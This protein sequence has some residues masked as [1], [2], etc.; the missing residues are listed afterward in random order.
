MKQKRTREAHR[1][2]PNAGQLQW[3]AGTCYNE[4]IIIVQAAQAAECAVVGCVASFITIEGAG[5]LFVVNFGIAEATIVNPTTI[6]NPGPKPF[7]TVINSGPAPLFF[8][9]QTCGVVASTGGR[10]SLSMIAVKFV[11]F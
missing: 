9:I 4:E 1:E 2:T 3:T 11:V 10:C 7:L 8:V 5:K 6:S